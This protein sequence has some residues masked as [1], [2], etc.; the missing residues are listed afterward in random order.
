[1][2]KT[3]V[4]MD[5][6]A[7]ARLRAVQ[8]ARKGS[9]TLLG[10][11]G[12]NFQRAVD[13]V[14]E[15]QQGIDALK[16]PA[17]SEV[18][19]RFKPP[20][21][22]LIQLKAGGVALRPREVNGHPVF[23]ATAGAWEASG[24]VDGGV[25]PSTWFAA[26]E[27]THGRIPWVRFRPNLVR[28]DQLF[29]MGQ[30]FPTVAIWYD[31]YVHGEGSTQAMATLFRARDVLLLL[32]QL[33]PGDRWRPAVRKYL[34]GYSEAFVCRHAAPGVRLRVDEIDRSRYLADAKVGLVK[35]RK[36]LEWFDEARKDPALVTGEV[37]GR[38]HGTNLFMPAGWA[39]EVMYHHWA[40]SAELDG[41]VVTNT[42]H[43]HQ[44][45]GRDRL[46]LV[47]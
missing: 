14:L 16:F 13:T 1:M 26:G 10:Y 17:A 35:A 46:S 7:K 21:R 23:P 42:F 8:A 24:C 19:E 3:G 5:E 15:F 47:R 2:A 37:T 12:G 36:A 20:V 44:V 41:V 32:S 25:I 34:V 31:R 45:S 39:K 40:G 27:P 18:T 28:E 4:K 33:F 9:E 29:L 43:F 30:A 38:G 6:A 11:D 22:E